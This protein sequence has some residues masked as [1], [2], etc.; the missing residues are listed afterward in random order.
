MSNKNICIGIDYG[1]TNSVVGVIMPGTTAVEIIASDSG[2]RTVPSVVSFSNEERLIGS[3]AKAQSSGNPENTI[4]EAKRFVGLAYDDPAVQEEIKKMPYKVIN[5][6]NTPYFEVMYKGEKKQFSAIEI[7]SMVIGEMKR[8]A[9][10]FLGHEVSNAVITCP[11]RFNDA[12]RSAVKDA[13]AIAGLNVL[14]IINEPTAAAMAYHL[15]KVNSEDNE[16]IVLI[17]D[18]GGGTHDVS[19][20]TVGDG[21]CEVKATA[22][23]THL[24]GADF[25]SELTDYLA[26]QFRRKSGLNVM[27]NKRA[28]RRLRTAA[29]RAKRNLSTSTQAQIEIDSLMDGV[30]YTDVLTRARFESLSQT[31]FE[32]VMNPISEVLRNASVS[33]DRVDEI[34]LVGGTTRIPKIQQQLRTYFNG[35]ELCKSI[36]PDECVAYGAAV[37]G[38]ILSGNKTGALDEMVLID[39]IPLSLGL[40]TAGGVMTVL[41]KRDSTKP[42]EKK[43][44]FSTY[45]DNQPGVLIQVYEGERRMTADC[46]KLGE[47]SLDG[48]PPMPR[49]VPQ[50]EVTFSVDASGILSVSAMEKSTGKKQTVEIKNDSGRLSSDE[51]DK[52]VAD[53]EKYKAE[54]ELRLAKITARNELESY[55]FQVKSSLGE[56]K[57]KDKLSEEER[58]SVVDKVDEVLNWVDE[59][60]SAEKEQ[61]EEKRKELET[62][63]NPIMQR[64]MSEG[65]QGAEVPMQTGNDDLPESGAPGPTIEEV[66]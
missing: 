58:T 21:V 17:V 54:D 5:K 66:D 64:I 43:Q 23:D 63:F 14:R 6:N 52:I 61:F 3:A 18:C 33:K 40:E 12:Q 4:Y 19:L 35:K 56:D 48:I 9:E 10:T 41:L 37:Q 27:E 31:T 2:E 47:F 25:D 30:D 15:D 11:A 46:N 22:G 59:N 34:V 42:C 36:N 24:G 49:G 26:K 20:L 39:T 62:V 65:A 45:S 50:V 60:Y 29:E 1:T 8:I 55:A 38:A 16:K 57:L 13:G 32:R 51:I 44:V 28:M 53:A 7:A